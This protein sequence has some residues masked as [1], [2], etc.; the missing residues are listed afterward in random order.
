MIQVGDDK[1]II[2]CY[3]TENRFIMNEKITKALIYISAADVLI[4]ANQEA[5]AT[6]REGS[7]DGRASFA[8][9]DLGTAL[10]TYGTVVGASLRYPFVL[11]SRVT[12][13]DAVTKGIRHIFPEDR[14]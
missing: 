7:Q 3:N 14:S 9:V 4:K 13:L 10:K 1:N 2:I 5:K 6:L 12:G 11:A 8:K